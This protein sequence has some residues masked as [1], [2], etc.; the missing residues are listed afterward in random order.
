MQKTLK[1]SA[2][3]LR[4]TDPM[5]PHR[6]LAGAL[7]KR[8]FVIAITVVLVITTFRCELTSLQEIGECDADQQLLQYR[9]GS[10]N[11]QQTSELEHE[12]GLDQN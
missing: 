12:P 2:F 9:P 8:L 7:K 1:E 11:K 10:E 3:H 6:E 4:C 5:S